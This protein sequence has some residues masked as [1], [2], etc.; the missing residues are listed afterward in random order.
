MKF[1]SDYKGLSVMMYSHDGFG[2]GHFKRNFSIACLGIKE[3]PNST[4]LL[5]SGSPSLPFFY[6]P[7]GIDYIKLP[8]IIKVTNGKWNSRTLSIK[9]RKFRALRAALIHDSVLIF[10]PDIFLVDYIPTGVWNELVPVLQMLK[11]F[12]NRPKIILGLRDILDDPEVTRTLWKQ[13]GVYDVIKMYYDRVF[14]Y[15]CRELFDT[16]EQYGL[17]DEIAEKIKYSGYLA[18]QHHSSSE[19]LLRKETR[20]KTEKRILVIAGGGYDAYPMMRLSIDALRNIYEKISARALFITGPLMKPEEQ[21]LIKQRAEGLPFRIM[22]S[23]DTL[24]Y[25]RSSDLI[26]T[27]GGYNTLI[28][29]LSFRKDIIV[30]PRKGPSKEQRIRA[31]LFSKRGFITALPPPDVTSPSELSNIILERLQN[32]RTP[33]FSFAMDGLNTVIREIECIASKESVRSNTLKDHR[34]VH[35]KYDL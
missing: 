10:K 20:G 14:I 19:S 16:A 17:N 3:L 28:D 29:S 26:I 4:F 2:L 32:P 33:R 12:K 22:K 13:E 18:P 9:Q 31:E 5:L 34:L 8:S 11:T 25:L 35:H 21:T 7:H 27:M 1:K 15:G 6:I 30:I 23:G 24:D